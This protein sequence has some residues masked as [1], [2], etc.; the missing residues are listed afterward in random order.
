MHLGAL[1][2]AAVMSRISPSSLPWFVSIISVAAGAAAS[3]GRPSRAPAPVMFGT[4]A[5][6]MI[7]GLKLAIAAPSVTSTDLNTTKASHRTRWLGRHSTS[8]CTAGQ[9]SAVL[10]EVLDALAARC[11]AQRRR[12]RVGWVHEVHL[13]HSDVAA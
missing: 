8:T 13:H 7:H 4:A 9:R 1:P 10:D 6:E 5:Y 2:A 11:D 12:F 3:A